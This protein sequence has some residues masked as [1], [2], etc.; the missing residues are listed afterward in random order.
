MRLGNIGRR[1]V[2]LEPKDTGR[3]TDQVLVV[4]GDNQAPVVSSKIGQQGDDGVCG[5]SV[6]IGG[7]LVD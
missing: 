6:E 2:G 3:L 1:Y 5:L 4:R 7:G